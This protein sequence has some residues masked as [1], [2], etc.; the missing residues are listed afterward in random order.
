MNSSHLKRPNRIATTASR[1]TFILLETTSPGEWALWPTFTACLETDGA[2]PPDAFFTGQM[3]CCGLAQALGPHADEGPEGGHGEMP[4][5]QRPAREWAAANCQRGGWKVF[6]LARDKQ[7]RRASLGSPRTAMAVV[8]RERAANTR[9]GEARHE[10][11][12]TARHDERAART[13]AI[14]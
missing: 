8:G 10:R 14:R 1:T 7:N 4:P 6:R 2:M 13:R 12:L 11:Q 3:G 9:V 5:A